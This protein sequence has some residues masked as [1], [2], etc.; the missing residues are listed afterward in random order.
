MRS[1]EEDIRVRFPNA[2]PEFE[3]VAVVEE[4]GC[5]ICICHTHFFT[6]ALLFSKWM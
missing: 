5:V 6:Y 2:D 3:I 1:R 4:H